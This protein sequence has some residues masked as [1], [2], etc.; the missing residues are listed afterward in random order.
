MKLYGDFYHTICAP[1]FYNKPDEISINL[2]NMEGLF[3]MKRMVRF[4]PV[5]MV[6]F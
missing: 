3:R 5:W 4:P 1:F 2:L 6:R